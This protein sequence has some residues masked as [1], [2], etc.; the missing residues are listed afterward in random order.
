MTDT[1]VEQL[2]EIER[3]PKYIKVDKTEEYIRLLNEWRAKYRL[4]DD[5]I[6]GKIKI[7]EEFDKR[8]YQKVGG[9][10]TLG[11]S[12]FGNEDKENIKELA[13]IIGNLPSDNIVNLVVNPPVS[14]AIATGLYIG[15]RVYDKKMGRRGF[16]SSLLMTGALAMAIS[17]TIGPVVKSEALDIARK[18]ANYVQEIIERY[19]WLLV[20]K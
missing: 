14:G 13:D 5:A 20:S 4:V 3:I 17:T 15:G 7:P 11:P 2:R 9:L 10:R 19:R 8:V 18:N 6:E 12:Y 1:L 16:L